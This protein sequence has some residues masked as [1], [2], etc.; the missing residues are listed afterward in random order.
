M[1]RLSTR[2][3]LVVCLIIAGAAVIWGPAYARSAS[4]VIRAAQLQGSCSAPRKCR[5]S[6]TRSSPP[7]RFTTRH[8]D[9]RT[10]LYRPDAI[11]RA[12]LLVPGVHAMGIDEPRLIGLSNELA[13]TGL[14]V[15]TM[16][17]PDLAR[18][19]FTPRDGGRHRGRRAVAERAPRPRRPTARSG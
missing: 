4:L 1:R 3:F 17:L 19:R 6:T 10:R 5:R 8:G 15:V 14:G 11:R 16:E 9:V 18:Y 13:A 12:V 2:I 7:P